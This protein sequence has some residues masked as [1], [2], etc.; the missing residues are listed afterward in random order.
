MLNEVKE[1]DKDHE[2]EELI[3]RWTNVMKL[4]EDSIAEE[5][6]LYFCLFCHYESTFEELR[7][8]YIF[9]NDMICV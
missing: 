1:N 5:S 4:F 2:N 7:C 6:A 3:I 8:R 9:F